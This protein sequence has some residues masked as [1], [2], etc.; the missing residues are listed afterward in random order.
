LSQASDANA[1]LNIGDRINALKRVRMNVGELKQEGR[2][3]LAG[4]EPIPFGV[5]A[6]R[7]SFRLSLP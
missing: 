6:D 4:I 1:K 5:T 3:N 2:M 7:Q